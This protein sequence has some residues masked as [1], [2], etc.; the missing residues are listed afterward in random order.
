MK[1]IDVDAIPTAE[2]L[3]AMFIEGAQEGIAELHRQSTAARAG[4]VAWPEAISVMRGIAHDIK[5]QGG[6]FGYPLVTAIGNSLS[7]LLKHERLL[8]DP[9][10]ELLSAHLAAL[11][12]IMDKAIQGDGGDLGSSYVERL[13]ALVTEL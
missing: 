2:E 4:N 11:T 8:S 7:A 3:Q 9:G 13:D 5:G 10:L 1:T 6:S 12:A